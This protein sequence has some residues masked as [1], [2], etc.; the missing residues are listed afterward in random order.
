MSHNYT[1]GIVLIVIF[2]LA[3]LLLYVSKSTSNGM[4]IKDSK[5]QGFTL[6]ELIIVIVL[7]GILAAVAAPRYLTFTRKA[8]KAVEIAVVSQLREAVERYANDKFIS[9]GRYEYPANPFQLVEVS[10]Y[11]GLVGGVDDDGNFV[12]DDNF[13]WPED[14][15]DWDGKWWTETGDQYGD[16]WI[17]YEN[18]NNQYFYWYYSYDDHSDE[19]QDDRGINLEYSDCVGCDDET[20]EYLSNY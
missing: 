20:W 11:I 5:C 18:R 6:I 17:G 16:L 7:L 8:E 15:N 3:Q 14:K 12:V 9:D 13:Q 10:T 4:L 19:P 2:L 1:L